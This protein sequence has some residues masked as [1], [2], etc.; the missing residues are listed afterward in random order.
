[1]RAQKLALTKEIRFPGRFLQRSG[2][3]RS[4]DRSGIS[5]LKRAVRV[6]Y[7]SPKVVFTRSGLVQ[8]YMYIGRGRGI[9]LTI[10]PLGGI[11]RPPGTDAG[12]AGVGLIRPGGPCNANPAGRPLDVIL[13]SVKGLSFECAAPH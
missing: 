2:R 7:Q 12:A 4:V 6:D 5:S 13:R 1:M 10:A 11:Q 3:T 9:L 8:S